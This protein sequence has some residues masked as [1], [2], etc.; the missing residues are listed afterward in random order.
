MKV[1]SILL[2]GTLVAAEQMRSSVSSNTNP[3]VKDIFKISSSTGATRDNVDQPTGNA[4]VESNPKGKTG[5][6]GVTPRAL[7]G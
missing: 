7:R 1:L 4:K 6:S 2:F 5:K 3:N